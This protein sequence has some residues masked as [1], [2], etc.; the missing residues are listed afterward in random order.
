MLHLYITPSLA[1]ADGYPR[2][3]ARSSPALSLALTAELVAVERSRLAVGHRGDIA[4]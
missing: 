2:I 3:A 1:H 4:E